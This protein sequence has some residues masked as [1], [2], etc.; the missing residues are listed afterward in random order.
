MDRRLWRWDVPDF[1]EVT[2]ALSL[3]TLRD[4]IQRAD[5][6]IACANCSV[7]VRLNDCYVQKLTDYAFILQYPDCGVCHVPYLWLQIPHGWRHLCIPQASN[8][9]MATLGA[10]SSARRGRQIDTVGA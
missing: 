10:S 1:C 7:M 3:L 8:G 9:E 6:A 4:C 2:S 5:E